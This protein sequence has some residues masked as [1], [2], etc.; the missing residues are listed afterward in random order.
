[1]GISF[2]AIY[3]LLYAVFYVISNIN[4]FPSKWDNDES[5]NNVII[6]KSR[7]PLII[8]NTIVAIC[9]PP[10][11]YVAFYIQLD[12]VIR[13]LPLGLFLFSYYTALSL[14]KKHLSK[15]LFPLIHFFIRII[16]APLILPLKYS[17]KAA[18]TAKNA[19]K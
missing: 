5:N 18:F 7:I 14:L 4:S 1:M 13:L 3:Y 6:K 12:G 10:L 11:L 16:I 2:S 17:S 8:L 9:A 15:P 19:K